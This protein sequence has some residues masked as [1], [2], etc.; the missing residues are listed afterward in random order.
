MSLAIPYLLLV[1]GFGFAVQT[2]AKVFKALPRTLRKDA[3]TQLMA[4]YFWFDNELGEFDIPGSRADVYD[5]LEQRNSLKVNI[6]LKHGIYQAW[7]TLICIF[8]QWR[9]MLIV[10]YLYDSFPFV[11]PYT[12]FSS[13][14]DVLGRLPHFGYIPC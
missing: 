7:T 3:A 13:V 1:T 6:G 5:S 11:L 9:M 4:F 8:M 10:F 14:S 12:F 2:G